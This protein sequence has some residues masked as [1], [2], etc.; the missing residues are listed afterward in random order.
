[1]D[2][3]TTQEGGMGERFL[4]VVDLGLLIRDPYLRTIAL[5]K[6]LPYITDKE[7]V[8]KAIR[9]AFN[10]LELISD[11]IEHI[12]ALIQLG[13][14]FGKLNLKFTKKTFNNAI[15]LI[16]EFP[17]DIRDP[18]LVEA[19]KNLIR[20]GEL[21]EAIIH[22]SK[23]SNS[24]IKSE[25]M[26]TIIR[27][28]ISIGKTRRIYYILE[29][30]RDEPYYSVSRVET[31]NYLLESKNY[32]TAIKLTKELKNPFWVKEAIKS[33]IKHLVRGET[34]EEARKYLNTLVETVEYLSKVYNVDVR[35]DLPVIFARYGYFDKA[36]EL[37]LSLKKEELVTALKNTTRAVMKTENIKLI[38]KFL[39]EIPAKF[40][41]F[42][43]KEAMNYILD[44]PKVEHAY[45]V[46]YIQENTDNSKILAKIT[47]YYTKLGYPEFGVQIAE[48]ITDRY[49]KS[50]A[51]G[52]IAIYLL[53]KNNLSKALDVLYLI[54][55]REI[56]DWIL[57]ETVPKI[58]R[59]Y[60]E[61]MLE[62]RF[63]NKISKELNSLNDVIIPKE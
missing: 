60:R 34:S 29:Q 22:A 39:E 2:T 28:Y 52:S 56:L 61:R 59:Y 9:E 43:F 53:K 6:A 27:K 17:E 35:T 21:D 30:I 15:S 12:K 57:S 62:I 38:L 20:L 16:M 58:S 26:T 25:V 37:L 51:L 23:I 10:S 19:V 11:P 7:A 4:E 5:A 18:L 44:N 8:K 45:I 13:Y 42:V 63:D 33:I 36:I 32:P 31:I 1:M 49:E 41:E 24:R 48:R 14:A 55:D 50:L 46:K 40:R 47:G 54:E 3:V